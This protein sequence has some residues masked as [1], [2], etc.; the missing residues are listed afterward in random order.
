MKA[1]FS[2]KVGIFLLVF[3][4]FTIYFA[5]GIS[6]EDCWN[7][8]ESSTC[9]ANSSCLWHSDS[10][11]GWCEE[12][13]C[14][15]LYTQSECE[16]V[17]VSDKNCTWNA[18][19]SWYTCMDVSCW[20]FEGTDQD[21]C[22]SNSAGLSCTWNDYCFNAGGG[23][24][25]VDCWDYSTAATCLNASG[26][27]WGQ[28]WDKG[29]WDYS[30]ESECRPAKDWKGYNCTWETE[31]SSS[32]CTENGCWKIDNS[33]GCAAS[34]GR[35]CIWKWDSC[36]EVDCW[37]W[38]YT[39]A[40]ACVNNSA[41]LSCNW[42]GNY[43]MMKGCWNYQDS[44]TCGAQ[45][46]CVWQ[47]STS[48]GW[49]EEVNCWTWDSWN[50]GGEDAC[51]NNAYGLNCVWSG[52]PPGDSDTGWCFMDNSGVSCA[53]KTT[54]RDCMDTFYCWWQYTDWTDTSEGGSCQDPDWSGMGTTQIFNEW[55]PGCYL[56]D[57]NET[58]CYYLAGCDYDGVCFRNT[59]HPNS[60][61][62]DDY[63][64]NCSMV[65]DSRLCSS[66]GMLS[67]C[68]SWQNSTCEID[69]LSNSCWEQMEAP[70]VGA[71]FCEDYS[72]YTDKQV[73]DQ[74]AG[75]P[76]YMPCVWDNSTDRCQ[77]KASDVF[78]NGT[79]SLVKI[80]N[81]KNCVAAG[82]KWLI[83][84]YCESNIS[85]P[86]GRCEYKFEEED[87][88]DKTC[89]GCEL[90]DSVGND[91]NATNAK[92]ACEESALG[93]CAFTAD[94][95][96]PNNIGYCA[97]RE[98]FKKGVATNCDDSCGD[99]TYKGSTTSNDTTKR[100]S[101]YCIN[102]KANSAAGGCKWFTDNTT[103]QG[104][105]CLKKGDSTCEDACDR[106]TSQLDCSNTGRTAIA[107]QSGSCIWQ[108]TDN[109]GNCVHNTGEDVEI[110]WDGIDNT[111]DGMID[112]GDPGCYS[113]PFC[114]FVEGDCF[115]WTTE[116]TCIDND[117]EWIMDKWGSW[118][119]FPGA[120][121]WRY[122]ANSTYCNS[123]SFCEWS[124]S[125]SGDGWCEM[126]WSLAEQCMGLD[127]AGCV[128][129]DPTCLWSNDT[130]CSGDGYGTTW[131]DANGGWC[132]YADY[133]PK[134]CW[135]YQSS[136]SE[137]NNASGCN[138]RMDSYSQPHCE[139]NYSGN[140]W[141]YDTSA[142]CTDVGCYWESASWG[143]WCM[144]DMEQCWSSNTEVECDAIT[145]AKCNWRNY[146]WGANCE[147]ACFN[148][149]LA[150]STSACDAVSGC[151]WV[152]EMGWCEEEHMASCGNQTLT[153][154][155][156]ACNAVSGCK[157]R[158]PGWCDPKGG[159]FSSG[160]IVGGGGMGGAMGAEC[161]KYDGNQTSCTNKSLI[162]ISCGW[163]SEPTPF[164]DVDWSSDCWQYTTEE[165]G[166]NSTN[167]CWFFNDTWNNAWCMNIADQCWSNT[168]LQSDATSCDA[169]LY[170]NSTSWNTCEPSCFSYSA[171][172]D[173]NG[174]GSCRWVTGWCNPAGMNAM[175]DNMQH[176]EQALL[177]DDVCDGSETASPHV[178]MC[179]L[180]IKDM[181]DAY[182]FG[183]NVVSVNNASFC[184]KEKL[185][186]GNIGA[187]N[188]TVKYFVYLDTDGS[189]SGGCTLT[190]DTSEEGYEFRF[191][192]VSE[193]VSNKS[194]ATETFNAYQ[195]KNSDWAGT[196]IKLSAWKKKMCSDLAGVMVAVQKSDLEKFPK[197]Y[198]S[199]KDLRILAT[200]A[201]VD[202]NVTEPSDIA[203]PE[204]TTP[205]SIDFVINDVFSYGADVAKFE[206]ILKKGFVSY[207]DCFNSVDD[208]GDGDTDCNDWDCQMAKVCEDEGINAATYVDTTVPQVV[209]VRIE[210]YP[211]GALIMYDTNKPTNG[212]LILYG[213]DS[214]CANGTAPTAYVYDVGIT[215][216]TV[217]EFKLWHYAALYNDGGT[218]SL[219]ADLESDLTYYFKL[220][221]CDDTG[222]CALSQ[223]SALNTLSSLSKCSF[224]NF[225]TRLK[226]P[227]GWS[228]YYDLDQN[229]VY[230]HWQGQVCGPKAGMKT[231][232]TS[233][234]QANIKLNETAG[235]GGFEF[236]NVTLTK[237][238]LNDK[239]RT[240]EGSGNLS[241]ET[242][243]DDDGNAISYVG[244][245]SE[246]RDKIINSL[247]PQVCHVTIP[248]GDTACDALWHCDDN[249]DN[250][251]DRT[252]EASSVSITTTAC[253][254]KI[255][256]CEFSVW[257]GGVPGSS[258]SGGA[259]AGGGSGC[260]GG[261]SWTCTEWGDCIDGR[262][263]RTCTDTNT[264]GT[265]INRPIT[266][267]ACVKPSGTEE[268]QVERPTP[269][270]KPGK[271]VTI[272]ETLKEIASS[273][274][275]KAFGFVFV[276]AAIIGAIILIYLWFEREKKRVYIY[277]QRKDAKRGR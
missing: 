183:A 168:S 73:C 122:D 74:I 227:S 220:K 191:K 87:N 19:G 151:Y 112:C 84:N 40:T 217:T 157:F 173:C 127:R 244:M 193:W 20:S 92:D 156:T 36:Q 39:N 276:T 108:G 98:Q 203:G 22:E 273:K 236:F 47:A 85:V 261:E 188:D 16:G 268:D 66:I 239:V 264:C 254:W 269:T 267:K 223:C 185:S 272:Q 67:T 225:V 1:N 196:D 51:T 18:G 215:S 41:D 100:P 198:D 153:A 137:C 163:F 32:W 24:S 230:E 128:A 139:I 158:E 13:N 26:C 110:C 221:L 63:G 129:L 192:Y 43:C 62:I 200:T 262:Q 54:E 31:G 27:N 44:T 101:Y 184:N 189:T 228:V 241:M 216:N 246:A 11:G 219:T 226:A 138:W 78:G 164:C 249:G 45:G 107:N 69:R 176:G 79:Q 212:T 255:P 10:W 42:E 256:N 111:D 72:A 172:A 142:A 119:D 179:G 136:S 55:N 150:N 195:C 118:C 77:F 174:I 114:G 134:N 260:I 124:N 58:N 218:Y 23:Y 9:A 245:I 83:E 152:T 82:G 167:N 65:T 258:S 146:T 210:E 4:F 25:S 46:E 232:Y 81:Q 259:G 165:G 135:M 209:G 208:D 207:E 175:F 53:N 95:N 257:S 140:C 171:E 50:G 132:D 104:G 252:T 242:T 199:T 250:C 237:T 190:H 263:K 7:Y 96:A 251:I 48:Y 222:K 94:T 234:R 160:A 201:D 89:F 126:D 235:V 130:W 131:C 182:G 248:R 21:T 187:G 2:P 28:C 148:S 270:E 91:V 144:N 166:C 204:W 102:S 71:E 116:T 197:L 253:T 117:C 68:C 113:D 177:G 224:C 75:D 211:D 3:V 214:T 93:Y 59:S 229:G 88:C 121:C 275:A 123:Q 35:D 266:S 205:G 133:A 202:H 243:V 206:D 60:G 120:A 52:N 61:T 277:Y 161:Y 213:A 17:T 169:N 265:T 33:T 115:G 103:N 34:V 6:A 231:N 155:A 240:I 180:G 271:K 57:M 106:C 145:G 233:G 80:D 38:D 56:F 70:P 97:A 14:W 105:Y 170:C 143:G 15:S 141:Q 5:L 194:K 99:C 147:P 154:N 76:W 125:T 238:G 49:C 109:D 149:T 162:N 64:L 30:T 12:L 274:T 159:G 247:H 37:N 181:G 86:I 8:A 90:K 178:D 186:N 29:C